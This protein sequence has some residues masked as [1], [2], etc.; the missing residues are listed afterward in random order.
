MRKLKIILAMAAAA[1]P[2]PAISQ[3]THQIYSGKIVNIFESFNGN[4][5]FRVTLNTTLAGCPL[6]FAY[7][8]ASHS[9]YAAYVSALMTAASSGKTTHIWVTLQSTGYCTIDEVSVDF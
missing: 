6:N 9:N 3:V 7:V 8:E 1:L 2:I 4:L 5:A